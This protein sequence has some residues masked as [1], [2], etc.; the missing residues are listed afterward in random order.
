MGPGFGARSGM[1]L[2]N[3]QGEDL[4]LSGMLGSW[5]TQGSPAHCD[6]RVS[7]PGERAEPP[8]RFRGQTGL[9]RKQASLEPL[10]FPDFVQALQNKRLDL[11][12]VDLG[13]D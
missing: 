11:D 12:P 5:R 13:L 3:N 8:W 1:G 7:L 2:G 4:A 10:Y 6:V 9:F